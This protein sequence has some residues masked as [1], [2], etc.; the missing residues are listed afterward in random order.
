M[1][2]E[3]R[4]RLQELKDKVISQ[5]KTEELFKELERRG[6]HR[7]YS[8]CVNGD[9]GEEMEICEHDMILYEIPEAERPPWPKPI[10]AHDCPECGNDWGLLERYLKEPDV[11]IRYDG[12]PHHGWWG[13]SDRHM[14][15]EK[16][17]G[18]CKTCANHFYGK[19]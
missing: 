11:L 10:T 1:V 17:I 19:Y 18:Q 2:V 3:T 6:Y 14:L 4:D 15:A 12:A 16:L 9:T 8:L 13:K 5:Y 7:L